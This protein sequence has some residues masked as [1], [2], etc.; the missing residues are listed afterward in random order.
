MFDQTSEPQVFLKVEGLKTYFDTA[1]GVARAVDG[2]DF[3]ILGGE[4]LGVVG[5]RAAARA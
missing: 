3:E 2:I 1:R 4:T 5:S